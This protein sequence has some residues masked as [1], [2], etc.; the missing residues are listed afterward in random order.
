MF[1]HA[2]ASS[3][4]DA[5]TSEQYETLAE[6]HAVHNAYQY[7]QTDDGGVPV[8]YTYSKA[9]ETAE[10]GTSQS[11]T[12]TYSTSQSGAKTSRDT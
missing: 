3:E 6:G 1:P 9:H 11:S 12:E 5:G 2:Q 4:P 8:I 7:T 10:W